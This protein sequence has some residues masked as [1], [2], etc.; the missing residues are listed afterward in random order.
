MIFAQEF[1]RLVRRWQAVMA[2]SVE[3]LLL[4]RHYLHRHGASKRTPNCGQHRR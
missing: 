4:G 1:E 2:E 3:A